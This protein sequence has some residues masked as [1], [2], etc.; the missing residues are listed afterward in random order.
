MRKFLTLGLTLLVCLSPVLAQNPNH[1]TMPSVDPHADSIAFAQVRARMDSIRQ[2]R[3][4]VAVVLA[5][6]GARGLAHMGMLRYME[7][8]GI[9]VDL[10][11]GTSMGGLVSG[12]YALGYDTPYIDSLVTAIDWSV[13]MSDKVPDSYESYHRRHLEERFAL[14]IPFHYEEG[15]VQ[16]RIRQDAALKKSLKNIETKTSDRGSEMLTQLGLSLPDGFLLGFNVRNTLSSIS[17]G[18]QDSLRFED[19]PIPFYCVATDMVSMHEMNWT[20]GDMVDA[21]RSTMAIPVYFRPVRTR[22]MILSDGGSR[23]NFP[24]DVA[25]AMG[26]DI[27]IGS[28]M[29]VPREY[30][31]L[32]NLPGLMMQNVS[33]LTTDASRINR[34]YADI[35]LTHTLE[36]YNMLSFDDESVKA[37]I[38]LGYEEALKHKEEFEALARKVGT[39][40][41]H[42]NGKRATDLGQ[43]KVLIDKID[44]TGITEDERDRLLG[45]RF[46]SK[47]GLYGRKEIDDI[48][49]RLYGSRVFES[50]TY[51]L[52][53]TEEPY[54]LVF[55]CQK[56]QTNELGLG[57]HIDQEE[58]VYLSSYIG[59]GTR[60]L[61]GPRLIG[62]L[63]LG[64]NP[65][66]N[67]EGAY[68][69][70]HNLPIVG[71]GVQGRYNQYQLSYL[72]N[73]AMFQSA[74]ARVNLFLEDPHIAYGAARLG[75]SLE[76]EPYE[77]YLGSDFQWKG[78]DWKS[79]WFS[80]F[81]NLKLETFNDGYFPTRGVRLA[82]DG[83]YVFNGYSIFLEQKALPGE[84]T[85][86]KVPAYF[87][88]VGQA[89]AA[90]TAGRLTFVPTLYLGWNSA[91]NGM[92]NPIHSLCAGGIIPG[93]H[94]DSQIPYFGYSQMPCLYDDFLASP[95]LDVRYRLNHTMY[96]SAKAALLQNAE[97]FGGLFTSRI[98][99]YAF[100]LEFGVKTMA[101]PLYLDAHWCD[102]THFG[103]NLSYG[104]FF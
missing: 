47:T 68:R 85:E 5:G 51:Q 79:H 39:S 84:H 103:I 2:Y 45:A 93:R 40:G 55:N 14:T 95:Q 30:A 92:I 8:L 17:V 20:D 49:A 26:A 73:E 42:R 86:G 89:S 70:K 35:L 37:I 43:E 41:I 50:V 32:S 102:Q 6:G 22:G 34:E 65:I 48:L 7:E 62:E 76:G 104:F 21:M 44:I 12:L 74:N 69:P 88:G 46:M 56:G 94:A 29:S 23:N 53:G 80:A 13:M 78:W 75:V 28:E 87:S 82:L 63:K 97:K 33:M 15:D 83:R 36:G 81:T 31:T 1:L 3:P 54:T 77:N 16:E 10:V 71:L 58:I 91:E 18:Y 4:T 101:G 99:S 25:R 72:G 61:S 60:K 67:L 100:G 98:D 9:P 38:Q 66:V 90:F 57:F 52:L 64:N 19:L 24:T 11:G 96:L 27:I 59:I